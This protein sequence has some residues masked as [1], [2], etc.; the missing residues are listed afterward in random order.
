MKII[1]HTENIDEAIALMR[2]ANAL[3]IYR[4]HHPD[5]GQ[6]LTVRFDKSGTM[7]IYHDRKDVVLF[8]LREKN[9]D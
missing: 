1:I 3:T 5:K 4:E 2:T 7:A 9:E 6:R 8:G